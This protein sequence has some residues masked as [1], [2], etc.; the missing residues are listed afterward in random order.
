MAFFE[1]PGRSGPCRLFGVPL[2]LLIRLRQ[3]AAADFVRPDAGSRHRHD[4]KTL[5]Y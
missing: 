1:R 2:T 4:H 5:E 3:L